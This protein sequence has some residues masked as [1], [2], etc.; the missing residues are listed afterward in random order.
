MIIKKRGR[1]KKDINVATL[2]H[3]IENGCPI[4]VAAKHL[5]VH[6]DTLYEHYKTLIDAARIQRFKRWQEIY[7]LYFEA[8]KE[9]LC[10][11]KEES[12]IRIR[13]YQAR[14]R[15]KR[16]FKSW[17]GLRFSLDCH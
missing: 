5:G 14:Y 11:A 8:L 1:R 15:E 17:S 2:S 7:I 13:E 4:T 10:R 6:R 9:K 12:R 16:R 3:M